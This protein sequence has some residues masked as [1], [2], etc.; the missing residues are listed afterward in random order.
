M[1]IKLFSDLIDALGKVVGGLKALANLPKSEREQYRQVLDDTNQLIH[2]TLNMIILR[3]GDILRIS[4]ESTFLQEVYGLENYTEWMET[5]RKFRLC[6]SLRVAVG[7]TEALSKRLKGKIS[8][9]D[10]DALLKQMH[11]ILQSEDELANYIGEHFADL[12]F[13]ARDAQAGSQSA[14]DIRTEVEATRDALKRERGKLLLQEV[15]L[16][17][18][19]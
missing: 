13:S 7:E 11:L 2:T 8:V 3:L 12:A 6:Q 16:L 5:E 18:L 19:V 9:N 1:D 14:K 15:E 10:W 4:D 17:N